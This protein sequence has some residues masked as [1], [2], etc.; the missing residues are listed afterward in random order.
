MTINLDFNGLSN[1]L[2]A[3]EDVW[4]QQNTSVWTLG[5]WG[6]AMGGEC[7][8]AQNIIKKIRRIE[9]GGQRRGQTRE[10]YLKK[11]G[12]ELF[13]TLAYIFIVARKAGIDLNQAAVEKYNITSKENDLPFY[14]S[15]VDGKLLPGSTPK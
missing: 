3:R 11:L 7:G 1:A 10:V 8:E 12:H 9:C 4:Q 2:N 13:D 6:N 15:V 5:D 14:L